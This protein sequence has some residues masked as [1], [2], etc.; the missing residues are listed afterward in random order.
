[1]RRFRCDGSQF[2]VAINLPK[3]LASRIENVLFAISTRPQNYM[4]CAPRIVC[5]HQRSVAHAHIETSAAAAASLQTTAAAMQLRRP[6]LAHTY[7][8]ARRVEKGEVG[9]GPPSCPRQ[10]EGR[11]RRVRSLVTHTTDRS[12]KRTRTAR[13]QIHSPHQ[14]RSLHTCQPGPRNCK[15]SK[16]P[17]PRIVTLRPPAGTR[18]T[19][20]A[21]RSGGRSS[22]ARAAW[23]RPPRRYARGRGP[24]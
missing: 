6:K 2:V 23:A 16:L 3:G 12:H 5:V 17:L 13:E 11:K 19:R 7:K 1:M 14:D 4:Y 15:A 22:L 10:L 24:G 21:T 9:S 8:S 20:G 18:G